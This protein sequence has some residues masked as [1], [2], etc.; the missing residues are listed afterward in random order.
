MFDEPAG[1][2][3]EHRWIKQQLLI[4]TLSI[5]EL[6]TYLDQRQLEPAK[7]ALRAIKEARERLE[8]AVRF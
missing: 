3:D 2:H 1:G 4:A 5:G 7:V 6:G 8:T